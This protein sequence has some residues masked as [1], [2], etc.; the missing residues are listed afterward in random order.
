[1]VSTQLKNISQIGSFPQLGVKINKK[2]LT[3]PPRWYIL[4]VEQLVWFLSH[5]QAPFFGLGFHS[6]MLLGHKNGCVDSV[7][8]DRVMGS[9]KSWNKD[10]FLKLKPFSNDF[11]KFL[12]FRDVTVVIFLNFKC[13]IKAKGQ[14]VNMK[15]LSRSCRIQQTTPSRL[16]PCRP[17][18]F[19]RINSL[20][21]PSWFDCLTPPEGKMKGI[22][23]RIG[24]T[25]TSR[26]PN[27]QKNY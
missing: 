17:V 7:W 15:F 16:E 19:R 5:Q 4:I 20:R 21:L 9:L 26:A 3:P 8:G 11:L 27:H 25:P 23:I 6:V 22:G 18:G 12:K 1:M 24:G 14:L 10:S 2:Y 13:N